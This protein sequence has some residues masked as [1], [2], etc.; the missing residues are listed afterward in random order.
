MRKI[1]LV[2]LLLFAA[3][4]AQAGAVYQFKTVTDAKTAGMSGKAAVEGTSVRLDIE[5]GDGVLL[6]DGGAMISTDGGKTFKVLDTKQKTYFELELEQL[7]GSLGA[8]A[9]SMGG[10]IKISFENHKVTVTKAGAGEPI[11]G[12]PT[13]K[14]VTDSSY[15]MIMTVMGRK[16]TTSMVSRTETWTTD[17]L[18][19]QLMTFV[20]QKGLKTGMP[21]LDK[22]IEKEAAQIKGFP[23]K[24]VVTATQTQGKKTQT[25]TTTTTIS[26][27]KETSVPAST[28]EI[29]AGYKET[30]SPLAGIEA[31]T[32]QK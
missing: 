1:A 20:Q 29:P 25:S 17:K 18:S 19:P 24:Q 13:T 22:F 30:E 14:Y 23:L 31:L 6:K 2:L 9:N 15:D 12:Y 8:I 4:A 32:K 26:G 5:K 16:N 28:F 11:E 7:L 21:E 27:I 3:A 10:M